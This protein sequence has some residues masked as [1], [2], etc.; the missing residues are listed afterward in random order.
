MQ[1]SKLKW[2]GNNYPT[3][4]YAS[5]ILGAYDRMGNLIGYTYS[6]GC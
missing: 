4:E 3:V 5:N 6:I 2:E 1:D